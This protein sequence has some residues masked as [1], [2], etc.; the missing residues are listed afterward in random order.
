MARKGS[1]QFSSTLP[2]TCSRRKTESS[3]LRSEAPHSGRFWEGVLRA[4]NSKGDCLAYRNGLL[5]VSRCDLI[6][7]SN[8]L[9]SSQG[10]SGHPPSVPSSAAWTLSAFACKAAASL[11]TFMLSVWMDSCSFSCLCPESWHASLASAPLRIA[12][13]VALA[14]KLKGAVWAQLQLQ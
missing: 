14:L 10:R 12:L 6:P 8:C 2:E 7:W 9:L 4:E 13:R 11:S 3:A 5:G 1:F